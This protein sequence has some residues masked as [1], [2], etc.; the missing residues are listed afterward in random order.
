M[1]DIQ[2]K[3]PKVKLLWNKTGHFGT[4]ISIINDYFDPETASYFKHEEYDNIEDYEKRISYLNH[5]LST[6]IDDP[7]YMYFEVNFY[8]ESAIDIYPED[9]DIIREQEKNIVFAQYQL[10][11]LVKKEIIFCSNQIIM[12]K[13]IMCD[14][15]LEEEEN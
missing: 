11:N 9:E 8:V 3:E 13:T 14:E 1:T 4:V 2:N 12:L 6:D 5:M 7:W 15:K 10:N